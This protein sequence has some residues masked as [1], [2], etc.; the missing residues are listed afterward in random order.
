MKRMYRNILE[1]V[2]SI[3]VLATQRENNHIWL[4]HILTYLIFLWSISS[5]QW[6]LTMTWKI[7]KIDSP[8]WNLTGKMI[9]VCMYMYPCQEFSVLRNELLTSTLLA[10]CSTSIFSH[11]KLVHSCAVCSDSSLNLFVYVLTI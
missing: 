6:K 2:W 7:N 10:T 9:C 5:I 1:P 8:L 3:T 11:Q 4:P